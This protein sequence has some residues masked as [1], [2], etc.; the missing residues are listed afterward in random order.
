MPH[1]IRVGAQ[2]RPQHT[3]FAPMR[4]AWL[5]AEEAGLDAL[6]TWDHFY[7]LFGPPEMWSTVRAMS[8]SRSGLR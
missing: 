6:F 3:Q 5:R 2:C 4:D 7:P 1:S 8:A